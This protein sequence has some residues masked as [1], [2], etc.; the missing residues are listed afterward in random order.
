MRALVP[1][2]YKV[3]CSSILGRLQVRYTFA[4]VA[5]LWTSVRDAFLKD[6]DRLCYGL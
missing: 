6:L 4:L 3:L 5:N 2:T 1:Q